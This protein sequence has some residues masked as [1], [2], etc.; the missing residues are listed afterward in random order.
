MKRTHRNVRMKAWCKK[1]LSG[2]DWRFKKI[3]EFPIIFIYKAMF[4]SDR[5]YTKIIVIWQISILCFNRK[6]V[7]EFVYVLH[8]SSG[9]HHQTLWWCE[10]D[11]WNHLCG[12]K[13]PPCCLRT[14]TYISH[15][16]KKL[17]RE[18]I[19][20]TCPSSD[21]FTSVACNFWLWGPAATYYIHPNSPCSFSSKYIFEFYQS[22]TV[23]EQS[24][25]EK[26]IPLY[27]KMIGN[28]NIF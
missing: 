17:Y 15:V 9:P 26:N 4:Y 20:Y 3:F 2:I 19:F 6:E 27:M 28:S 8:F 21:T 25:S 24:R 18:D 22:L 14:C 23:F 7:G 13:S 11:F 5:H 12:E 10:V 16:L 1:L